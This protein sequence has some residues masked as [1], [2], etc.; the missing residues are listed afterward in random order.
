MR[1]VKWSLFA[2]LLSAP[3]AAADL[4]I[5]PAYVPGEHIYEWSGL[6][7]GGNVGYRRVALGGHQEIVAPN[8][9][10]GALALIA[11]SD[12]SYSTS[13][14]ILGVQ[15]GI[16]WQLRSFVFGFEG[17]FDGLFGGRGTSTAACLDGTGAIIPAC[18]FTVAD[19]QRY[20]ATFR[21][22]AG[23]AVDRWLFYVTGGAAW[24]NVGSDI[25]LTAAGNSLVPLGTI[26]NTPVGWTAGLGVEAAVSR[27]WSVRLE[28]LHL[29][30]VTDFKPLVVTPG[31]MAAFGFNAATTISDT[32]RLRSDLV[33]VGAN[34]RFW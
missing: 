31:A 33:R 12:N 18:T 17:D 25:S 7:L 13:G 4:P 8:P 19:R 15:F 22:R 3:A 30:S 10:T 9:N 14:G 24:Q 2:V 32:V 34:Y 6:Y 28:Y 20:F 23:Y 26:F 1:F 29:Q 27:D 11:Q 21:G 16:N 5:A